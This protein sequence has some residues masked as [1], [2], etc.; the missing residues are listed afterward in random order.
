LDDSRKG[1]L[2]RDDLRWRYDQGT[3][4]SCSPVVW[5]DLLFVV[6]DDG[7]AR[8]FDAARGKLQ[9]RQRLPGKYKTSPLAAEG[10]IYFLNEEGLCTVIS[11]SPRFEKLAENPLPDTT[12]A[13][14]AVSDGKIFIRG[15]KALYCIRR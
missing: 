8:C 5:D 14:P 2:S 10:R 15:H 13:S 7:I 11:A 1:E 4:D 3:P 6:T 9:W 12:L